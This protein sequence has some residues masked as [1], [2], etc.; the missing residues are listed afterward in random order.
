MADCLERDGRL[1]QREA[2]HELAARFGDRFTSVT[3]A[4]RLAI[5]ARVL[6]A[7]RKAVDGPS[8]DQRGLCWLPRTDDTP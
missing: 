8:W 1:D 5:S 6:R 7:F 2:A 3:D 4:G